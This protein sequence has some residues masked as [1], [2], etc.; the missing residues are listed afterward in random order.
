VTII[1]L[2]NP[3]VIITSNPG[4]LSV[5]AGSST[6]AK[7][8]VTSLLGYGVTGALSNLNNYSLPLELDCDALPAHASCSFSYPTPDPSDANSVAVNPTTQGQVMMTLNTNVNVGTTTSSLRFNPAVYAGIFGLGMLGLA[9]GRKK[10]LRASLFRVVCALSFSALLASVSACSSANISATPIL[11]TPK[12]TF[13][14]T[15]TAKQVGSK[16]IPGSTP[17]TT[18]VVYGNGN[19]MSVPFTMSVTI[20]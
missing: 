6:T 12:G 4:T 13:M 20:Q 3:M 10:T 5:A 19:Q 11:T 17:G 18:Q 15:V 7:L 8:T 16:T 2:R 1:A 9:W 14:I